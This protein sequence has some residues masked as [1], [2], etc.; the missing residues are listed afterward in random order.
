MRTPM[1]KPV[2]ISPIPASTLPATARPMSLKRLTRVRVNWFVVGS[3]FGIGLSFFMNF[4]VTA[5]VLPHYRAVAPRHADVELTELDKPKPAQQAKADEPAPAATADTK[6]DAPKT[7]SPAPQEKTADAGKDADKKEP[8]KEEKE[9]AAA[10][11]NPATPAITYPRTVDLQVSR[12][13]TLAAMLIANHVQSSE[14][15][16][17]ETALKTRVN[18]KNLAVGQKISVTLARHETLGDAAAVRE[19]AIKLPNFNTIELQRK[20]SGGFNVAA[21]KEELKD[22]AYRGYGKVRTSLQQAARDAHIPANMAGDLVKAFSYDVDFQRDLHAGDTLEVLMD[23][24]TAADGRVSGYGTIRYA[25]L[26][27]HGHKH[28]IFRFKTSAGE[29][30]WYDGAGNNVKKSLLRTPINAAHITSGFGMRMHPLLGY[31]KMHKGV[32]FGAATGT[33]IMAAGDGTVEFKGWQNGYGNFVIIKHNSKYETAYGH[34][35]RFGPISVGN[36]VRQG[37]IIAYVGMT[38]GATGPHL[39]YEVRENE[40]QVNPVAK[41]FNMASGLTGKQLDSFK[42]AKAGAVKELASLGK[43]PG[44]KPAKPAKLASR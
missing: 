6:E 35:S 2:I 4:V 44:D 10:G 40:V 12:G 32:D 31:S 27:L 23:R 16:A 39:H 30:A 18:P 13:T 33:P 1:V 21:V 29:Y 38:G 41:Q 15:Q 9:L 7:Q 17:V 37:Q 8:Q 19:L 25:S 11:S 5:L 3:V 22:H 28:E 36:R 24:K 26:N 14:A 43:Q 20:N 42:A 34:I